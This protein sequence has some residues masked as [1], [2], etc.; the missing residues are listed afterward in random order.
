MRCASRAST[1][2][3]RS[4]FYLFN[5]TL[6][7]E[8]DKILTEIWYFRDFSCRQTSAHRAPWK[9]FS[10]KNNKRDYLLFTWPEIIAS[11]LVL[12]NAT[13]NRT[14]R[15]D[16]SLSN[17]LVFHWHSQNFWFNTISLNPWLIL[18]LLHHKFMS[19]RQRM[20]FFGSLNSILT[21]SHI[22]L[23]CRGILNPR[24][25]IIQKEL[26]KSFTQIKRESI[27]VALFWNFNSQFKPLPHWK[28]WKQIS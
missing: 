27:K 20:L 26:Q 3:F 6:N 18:Q 1:F 22:L 4:H 28:Q 8:F 17:N 21:F 11:K 9:L 13:A 12:V 23:A 15:T 19:L 10:P 24:N 16:R 14:A 25:P 7:S 2:N 5:S